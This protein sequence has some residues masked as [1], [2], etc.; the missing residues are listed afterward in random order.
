VQKCS[1]LGQD[2]RFNCEFVI[3]TEVDG[4]DVQAEPVLHADLGSEGEHVTAA[5][6]VDGLVF[7]GDGRITNGRG[8]GRI[9]AV[10]DAQHVESGGVDDDAAS[11]GSDDLAAGI[12]VNNDGTVLGRDA[13]RVDVDAVAMEGTGA[14]PRE[15]GAGSWIEDVVQVGAESAGADDSLELHVI[16]AGD[17]VPVDGDDGVVLLLVDEGEAFLD[18]VAHH[19]KEADA[20]ASGPGNAGEIAGG[21]AEA[22][23]LTAGDLGTQE[24]RKFLRVLEG[25]GAD[26]FQDF[27]LIEGEGW[28][29]REEGWARHQQQEKHGESEGIHEAKLKQR[30][31]Q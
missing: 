6:D 15:D 13:E 2:R 11:I 25:R 14:F 9:D 12:A 20:G 17:L 18:D 19:S 26:G 28:R 23:D 4:V 10:F 21:V 22:E 16:D 7:N 8:D 29:S 5:R 30:A 1:G 31:G 27:V 24:I 3:A